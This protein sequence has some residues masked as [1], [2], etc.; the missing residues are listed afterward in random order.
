ML[1]R[2]L[3]RSAAQRKSR[4]AV[5]AL[6]VLMGSA[7]VTALLSV[8]WDMEEKLAVEAR[9]FGA[10]V[11]MV[12]GNDS[13]LD[14]E[15]NSDNGGAGNSF[16]R[17]SD[18]KVI[19]NK[20]YITGMAPYLYGV[21]EVNGKKAVLA[22]TRFDQAR[23]VSPWWNIKGR[24]A[25]GA[26]QVVVGSKAAAK[27]K[28]GPG[29]TLTLLTVRK[30]QV[31][32]KVTGV[33]Q[34]GGPEDNQILV[35]LTVAQ[36][37]LGRPGQVSMVQVS[38]RTDRKEMKDVIRELE[39]AI[40]GSQGKVVKQIADAERN[41]LDKIRS[42][43]LLVT[44]AVL[45]AS[46]ISV[47][48]T[49]TSTVLERRKEIGI[50]KALGAENGKIARLFYAEAV[51]IG[52]AGG[53]AGYLTGLAASQVIGKTVFATFISFR[54]LVLPVALGAALVVALIASRWPVEQALKI[55]PIVTLRGE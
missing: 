46:V 13:L 26:G 7:M 55:D 45:L 54:L 52:L 34:G 18:I 38:A 36:E 27:L 19:G 50:M 6:A 9:R 22:G 8:S 24:W 23:K 20:E 10:N 39:Q 47:A 30:K 15:F 5:A 49:M 37:Y 44:V 4:V 41:L 32:A 51:L 2:L 28:V 3:G 43:M 11:L 25:E 35:D 16:I 29:D 21:L 17:D 40:P 12:P 33:L 53:L 31:K 42:L 14:V 48:S 1:G